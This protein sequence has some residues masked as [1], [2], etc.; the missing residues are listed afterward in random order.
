MSNDFK[1]VG[2]VRSFSILF[3]E[4]ANRLNNLYI[5]DCRVEYDDDVS[6][7]AELKHLLSVCFPSQFLGTSG[8]WRNLNVEKRALAMVL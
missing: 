1:P 7:M 8:C 5:A 2:W 6:P 4:G 3:F